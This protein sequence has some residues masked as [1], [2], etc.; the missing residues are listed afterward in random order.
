MT[1]RENPMAGRYFNDPSFA[2]AI[3]NLAGAFAP[4][5]P[6]EYLTAEKVKGLRTSNAAL[7]DAYGLAGN[8]FDK[9]GIVADL[10]DPSNSYYSV[11]T[12]ANTARRGQDVAA[13]A[14]LDTARINGAYGLAG[15]KLGYYDSM[16][17]LPP[18]IA[19]AI[20]APAFAPQSGAALGA[21]APPLSETEMIAKI[22]AEQSP[23]DQR[24]M[25]GVDLAQTVDP[26]SGLP[27]NTSTL[28]AIGQQP[29]VNPGSQA[30]PDAITFDRNGVRMGGFIKNG[31]FVDAVGTPLTPEE[32]GTAAKVGS[33]VGTNAE[34]GITG[35]NKTKGNEIVAEASYGKERAAK[36]LALIE[37]NAGV[38]GIP[39]TIRGFAQ[40]LVAGANEF[41]EVYGGIGSF[42]ELQSMAA[43]VAQSNGYTPEIAQ[44]FNYALEM[45]Y[46]AANM[47]DPDG[48]VGIRELAMN[49]D[50][51]D[52]GIAG[53]EKVKANLAV[54]MGQLE[55]RI[56]YGNALRTG[57]DFVSPNPA[58]LAKP[59][60]PA[61]GALSPEALKWI[62][63]P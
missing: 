24:A 49:M 21:P 33:P 39:G 22:M 5:S 10:Y 36:F 52:G 44:A 2:A 38:L 57:K 29:F 4:P 50:Q 1:T 30:A 51:Y 41:G 47:Q 28:D 53:N 59:G 56:A 26:V 13:A 62:E 58:E 8:D 18:E 20:G 3:S 6:E 17:G 12:A 46:L 23:E 32:A 7:A 14:A 60:A 40:D 37:N 42:D 54:L 19:A 61:A 11:D 25:V 9:L 45:A 63:G 35:S 43:N 15:T 34:L 31:Q 16:P 55:D 48:E 27:V